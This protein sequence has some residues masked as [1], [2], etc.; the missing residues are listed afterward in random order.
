MAVVEGEAMSPVRAAWLVLV[1]D[2]CGGG[3]GEGTRPR[4]MSAK[5]VDAGTDDEGDGWE[6][7]TWRD[8][9]GIGIDEFSGDIIP[10]TGLF[11]RAGSAGGI[12]V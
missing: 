9:E 11:R 7:E 12:F 4:W 10:E 3:E 1:D 5:S 6:F 8:D 2:D